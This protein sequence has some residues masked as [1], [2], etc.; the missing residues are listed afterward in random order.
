MDTP[1]NNE[2]APLVSDDHLSSNNSD[3]PSDLRIVLVGKVGAGKSSSGNTILGLSYPEGFKDETSPNSVTTKCEMRSAEVAGKKIDVIDT[4]GIDDQ[5]LKDR[6]AITKLIRKFGR[7]EKEAIA[8]CVNMS[9]PGPHVFLLVIKLTRFTKEERNAVKWIEDNF[10]RN[11]TQYIIILFTGG[12]ALK[13]DNKNIKDFV[14]AHPE[15]MAL[16]HRCG[17]RCHVFDNTTR[18]ETQVSKLLDMIEDVV[19]WNGDHYTNA[20]YKEAQKNV[21]KKLLIGV[22]KEAGLGLA[23]VVAA[24]LEIAVITGLVVGGAASGA[25]SSYKK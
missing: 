4:P 6:W 2:Y 24:P 7:A 1:S 19:E 22:A 13:R 17:Y 14:R 20:M 15:L 25:I 10:G 11:A 21:K 16:V 5:L 18:D 12:D 23:G 8:E 3:H 9:A